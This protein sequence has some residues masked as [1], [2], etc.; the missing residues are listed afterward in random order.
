[1]TSARRLPLLALA[2]LVLVLVASASLT[3][4]RSTAL[5]QV[6]G[7]SAQS[8]VL[9]TIIPGAL[10]EP[11]APAKWERRLDQAIGGRAMSVAV[12]LDGQWLYR[13]NAGIRRTPASN[14]KLLLSMALMDALS[15]NTRLPVRGAAELAPSGG[16]LQGPLWIIG[17]GNPETGEKTMRSLARALSDAGVDEVQGRVLGS[18]KPFSHDWSAPGWKPSFPA[19]EVPLPTALTFEGNVAAGKHISNPE[20]RA[21]IELTRRL[22]DIGIK[23]TGTP[24]AGEAPVGLTTIGSVPGA[25]L[26]TIVRNM[27]VP[28][29]N[30]RA[31]V[32]GKLLGLTQGGAP[33]SIAKGAEAIEDYAR[34][35]A[36]VLIDANDGSGLS[37][38]NRVAPQSMV[39]LLWV[40]E[41]EPWGDELLLTL[42]QA[43]QGTLS[44]RLSGVKIRAKTGSLDGI[45]ALSGWVWLDQE[46]GWAAFSI[47]SRGMSKDVASQIEDTIARTVHERAT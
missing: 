3:V 1:M 18:T 5:A 29:S 7:D 23:V 37:Y 16:V 30:F 40:A 22:R 15:P 17:S 2:S 25:S 27:N 14:E 9:S 33:G 38:E 10:T 45:S 24:G 35:A 31:E 13:H 36:D 42:P 6:G 41:D 44:G 34:D 8:V 26:D 28:S 20:K 12:G 11:A 19:T 39:E 47:I 43:G 46:N 4:G 32:L 21:A